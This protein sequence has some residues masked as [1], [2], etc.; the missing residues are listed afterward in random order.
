M[1]IW[2]YKWL[3]DQHLAYNSYILKLI[4]FK[5]I[6]AKIVA[7]IITR[8]YQKY[9]SNHFFNLSHKYT[10]KEVKFSFELLFKI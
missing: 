3:L 1:L 4:K 2:N 9:P 10:Q 7:N 6:F 8:T 5:E